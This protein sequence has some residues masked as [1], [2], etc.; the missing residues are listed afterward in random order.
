MED[1]IINEDYE[2][3]VKRSEEFLSKL[4]FWGAV[5]IFG[6]IIV[7]LIKIGVEVWFS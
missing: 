7:T 3:E 6:F 1:E 5:V 2:M 4:G